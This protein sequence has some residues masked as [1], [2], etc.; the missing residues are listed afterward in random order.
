MIGSEYL[1]PSGR[2]LLFY[3]TPFCHSPGSFITY[4]TKTKTLFS[5]D[6]FGSYDANWQLYLELIEGCDGCHSQRVCLQTGKKCP[7]YGIDQFHKRI[8]TSKTALS[9]ALDVIES[10]DIERIAPQHGS[11]IKSNV[12]AQIVIRHLRSMEHV[13]IDYLIAENK[14]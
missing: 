5:S 9:H 2:K 11:I 10:L 3:G 7:L 6:L 13:G 4:D 8:M 12:D 1:F 14:L